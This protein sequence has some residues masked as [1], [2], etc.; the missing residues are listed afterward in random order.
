ASGLM[1]PPI[2]ASPN[3]SS[4]GPRRSSTRSW[5]ARWTSSSEGD[6]MKNMKLLRKDLL[7]A[8]PLAVGWLMVGISH[9]TASGMA[10]SRSLRRSFMFF[11]SSPS[12]D[13]VQRA[14]HERVDDL[15]G[16]FEEGF[17]LAAIG[18]RIKPDA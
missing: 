15:R 13:D 7:M 18:G 4:N 10:M 12:L 14:V 6:E 8:I 5:T 3:P 2:A 17:G 11:I 9:P 1:R 16:P